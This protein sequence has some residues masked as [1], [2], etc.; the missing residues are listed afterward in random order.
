MLSFVCLIFPGIISSEIYSRLRK[1]ED[2]TKRAILNSVWFIFFVNFL[3]LASMYVSGR[4]SITISSDMNNAGFALK[5][6]LMST[7]FALLLPILSFF[8]GKAFMKIKK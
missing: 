4:W 7:V 8:F 5:Y 1:T 3:C 6:M 2:S